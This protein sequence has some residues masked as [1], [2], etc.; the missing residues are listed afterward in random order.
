MEGSF[1]IQML[2][3]AS[4]H[5]RFDLSPFVA[6]S[7][8]FVD[9]VRGIT[10]G[11]Q[12]TLLARPRPDGESDAWISLVARAATCGAPMPLLYR[13]ARG[14]ADR[15]DETM[16]VAAAL[17]QAA[18]PGGVSVI[19]PNAADRGLAVSAL[20][21]SSV[22]NQSSTVLVVAD[23]IVVPPRGRDDTDD[24]IVD[25]GDHARDVV[26]SL[27]TFSAA[28]ERLL[29]VAAAAPVVTII[30]TAM[31]ARFAPKMVNPIVG[32][33]GP[34]RYDRAAS[35][36]A[37]KACASWPLSDAVA[38]KF[39]A[40]FPDVTAS[41]RILDVAGRIPIVARKIGYAPRRQEI[42]AERNALAASLVAGLEPHIA[43]SQAH[44]SGGDDEPFYREL[45]TCSERDFLLDPDSG[46][47][48]R[49][50][51]VRVALFGI[52]G[53]GKTKFATA[54]ASNLK[55]QCLHVQASDIL[56]YKLGQLERN[57]R[58]VFQKARELGAVL[59]FDEFDSLG[60]S[61]SEAGSASY[62]VSMTNALL[63]EFDA[64]PLPIIIASNYF[65]RIDTAIRRRFDVTAELL[66]IPG[67]NEP[68]AFQRMLGIKNHTS[69]IG[70]TCVSDYSHAR[71]MRTLT[72]DATL[73]AAIE[74]V[75][76]ARD[77]R[78]GTGSHA[79]KI[80]FF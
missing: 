27:S 66:P 8:D 76:K 71:K 52:P 22:L 49:R 65:E 14:R 69:I 10:I 3:A 53:T 68:I 39:V 23:N 62:I 21:L 43:T 42:A 75:R 4:A 79:K 15:L 1:G 9:V 25:A 70:Q 40:L 45:I 19:N 57:L 16:A 63:V 26:E 50:A 31:D 73:G 44:R 12:P 77:I 6:L 11:A 61:R 41:R 55:C 37:V 38:G 74:A 2:A 56:A 64:H 34:L 35:I 80:G 13:C 67:E 20:V 46:D 72:G 36:A 58:L 18:L 54:I 5:Q 29:A 78:L 7:P 51:G 30:P 33:V 32:V 24:T 17:A 48:L 28:G 59:I 60:S 47:R